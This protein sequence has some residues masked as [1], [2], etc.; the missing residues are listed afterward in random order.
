MGNGSIQLFFCQAK[1]TK[2]LPILPFIPI[3]RVLSK[4]TYFYGRHKL[5]QRHTMKKITLSILLSGSILWAGAQETFPVN[6][7]FNKNHSCYAFTNANLVVDYQTTIPMA[8]LLIKDGIIVEAGAS[9]KIPA[10]AVTEDLKGKT[11]YPSFIDAF[12]SYGMPEVEKGKRSFFAPQYE[13][14]KKGAFGWN[15]AMKAEADAAHMFTADSKAADELRKLGFGTVLTQQKDGIARGS[16][17]VVLL[18][19]GA[20]QEQFVREKAAAGYSF[21]KGSSTQSNPESMMGAIALLR[22]TYY[23]AQW[24]ATTKNKKETNLSLEAFIALQALPQIFESTDKLSDLRADKIA[25]EFKVKYII[26]GAGNEYQRMEEIQATQDK[27]ILPLNFPMAFDVEDPFDASLVSLTDMKHWEMAPLNPVAFA[28]RGM[29]FALTTSDLKDKKEFW[30]NLRKS[31]EFGLD[32]KNALKA[33][34][35]APAEM[36]GISDK[37]G[38]LKAGMLAN[39]IITS[40]NIFDEKSIVYENWVNGNP[41][42][43]TDMNLAD[44]RGTFELKA[45]DKTYKLKITGEPEKLKGQLFLTDTQKV[46]ASIG[47]KMSGVTL[48]YELK[49]QGTVRLGGYINTNPIALAGK[50]QLPDGSW[51]TWS[52]E[53]KEA[54]KAEPVKK[55]SSKKY[56]PKIE[57]VLYPFS[58]Y[59]HKAAVTGP[60]DKVKDTYDHVLF[61]TLDHYDGI[62]IKNVT[63]WTNEAEGIQKNKCVYVSDGKIV[64]IADNIDI[65]KLGLVKILD[66]TGKHLTPGIIDEHSHIAISNGVNEGSQAST[67]EV[68]IG[69]VVNSEDIN[70]YRQLAGGVTAAQL[71]HGSANPIG[72]QSA[73]IKLRWGKS[74]EEMKIKGADG[75][76]KFALGENVKQSNWGDFNTVRFPQTRMGVEQVYA[77]CFI[78]AKEYDAKMKP[79]EASADKSGA[80]RRDLELDALAEILN[81]KRFITCHSY[82][83]SEILMLMKLGDSLGFKVNTFTHILEGYKVADKMQSRGIFASTFSDWWAYKMEVKDAIPYNGALMHNAGLVVAFNSDDAEMAR[84][85]NQEAAKAVKYGQ[86]SEEEALKFVT[87]NPAKMLHL[88][89][90]MGSIK[91][92]KE[93]DLVLWSDNPLS[94][95]AKAEKTIVDGIIYYDMD[96]DKKLRED[97]VKERARIIQEMIVEKNGGA[98]VSK[99]KPKRPHL[100][101]CDDIELD[102]MH[103]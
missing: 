61:Q 84:R 34:T 33:L 7:P 48:S 4:K 103:E 17:A 88:D 26:K 62:L 98:P 94:V 2:N 28:K 22:Q 90:R 73:L 81:K 100:Y 25:K 72:G 95:Y 79:F 99:P 31:I 39:F 37:V 8:T 43:V 41:Y 74:P 24:Y 54:Y 6:G 36:L 60:L 57:D 16:A 51:I 91:V 32:E 66:G 3:L 83:Q 53:L 38:S 14:A 77:D 50:G 92:G 76:I 85:L 75:F 10:G 56:I 40:G 20:D 30:K 86:V 12:T 15:Q 5:N 29:T 67:A 49:G 23:D 68:R 58:A 55:D 19:D 42:T 13:S 102:Y 47:E 52:E 59:G 80:P 69:D 1:N 93:A 18:G 63:V 21:D 70:I 27:F 96:Q 35:Q 82:V 78:R 65:P 87:L 11:I 101:T 64:R 45:G 9:V 89:S 97:L 71:L 46:T 44:L